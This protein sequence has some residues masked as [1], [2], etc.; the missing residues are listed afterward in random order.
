[1][2][3]NTGV[4]VDETWYADLSPAFGHEVGGLRKVL[5][6]EVYDDAVVVWPIVYIPERGEFLPS[7]KHIRSIDKRR[8]LN[9]VGIGEDKTTV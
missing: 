9:R 6:K 7:R 2:K 5:V 3:D 4:H 8:L 1:M